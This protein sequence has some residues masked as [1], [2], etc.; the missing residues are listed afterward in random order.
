[1]RD[2]AIRRVSN[3]QVLEQV[4]ELTAHTQPAKPGSDRSFGLVFTAFFTIVALL[5]LWRSGEVR[6]WALAVAVAFLL[7][8]WLR[9]RLLAPLNKLWMR[10]GL[11]LNRIV[12]PVMLLLIYVVAVLPTGLA[13]RLFGK[14]P[15]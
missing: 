3:H 7:P 13:L 11:L 12:S 14:D 6:L 4:P 5:P 10:F 9:P 2:T 8:A 15:L 1:M